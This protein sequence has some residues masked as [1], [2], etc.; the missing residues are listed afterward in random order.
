MLILPYRVKNPWK[1]FPYAT[2][3]IM[4]VNIL[5]YVLTTEYCLDIRQDVVSAYGFKYG[6]TSILTIFS[7]MFL[8]ADLFHIGGNLLFFWVFSPPVEDRLGIPRF[9][10]LYF[11]AGII[12]FLAQA[13]LDIMFSGMSRYGLGASGC[14]LGIIGAYLYLYPWSTVCVVY[15]FFGIFY[16]V[17]EIQAF[18]VIGAYML[19]FLAEAILSPHGGVANVAHVAGGITGLLFCLAFRMRRDSDRVSRAKETHS[20]MK[21]LTLVPLR[22]LEDMRAEDPLNLDI[23]HAMLPQAVRMGRLAIMERA[24]REAGPPLVEKDPAM[25]VTYLLQLSGDPQLFTAAQLMRLAHSAELSPHPEQAIDIYLLIIKHYPH[26]HE[27]E[28]M[29]YRLGLCYWEKQRDA[30]RARACL[31]ELLKRYPYGSMEQFAK[32][33][34]RKIPG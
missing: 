19:L 15:W 26:A 13:L 7:A 11:S 32:T 28:T 2:V 21:D 17:W 12:G 20:E 33:L 27:T 18:W 29:L 30:P 25:L 6:V 23:L 16:G 14:I 22:E 1:H 34:L 8:H 31:Q 9:L 3:S 24:F 4:A 5:V 10:L